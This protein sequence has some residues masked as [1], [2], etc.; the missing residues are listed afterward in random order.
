MPIHTLPQ[1]LLEALPPPFPTASLDA[2]AASLSSATLDDL[3]TE[4]AGKDGRQAVLSKLKSSGVERIGD[5][6]KIANALAKAD[7]L[8]T[9]KPYLDEVTAMS[10]GLADNKC[11]PYAFANTSKAW[12]ENAGV[13][14]QRGNDAFKGGTQ[15]AHAVDLWGAAI[16]QV[17]KATETEGSSGGKGSSNE[18]RTMLVSLHAN[19]AAAHLR[20]K[21]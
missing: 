6:Q 13:L 3:A 17:S 5:R 19:C 18:A 9:L 4:L 10:S 7:R 16:D 2:L 15:N 14:K 8:G 20:L 21:R 1:L 11:V 12:L